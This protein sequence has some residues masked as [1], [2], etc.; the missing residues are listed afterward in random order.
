MG[1]I[2]VSIRKN[3]WRNLAITFQIILGTIVLSQAL[4]NYRYF[5]ATKYKAETLIESNVY[6]LSYT[7]KSHNEIGN[8]D[9]NGQDT[10]SPQEGVNVALKFIKGDNRVEKIGLESGGYVFKYADDEK[11]SKP[12]LKSKIQSI[13]VTAYNKELTEMY[14]FKVKKGISFSDYFK[15]NNDDKLIPILISEELAGDNPVGSIVKLPQKVDPRQKDYKIIGIL[16]SS[17][18][19]LSQI[20]DMAM[21][22]RPNDGYFCIIGSLIN[23]DYAHV[24]AKFKDD[25][26]RD[27]VKKDYDKRAGADKEIQFFGLNDMA[28]TLLLPA[29][30]KVQYI[31]YGTIILILTSFGV[32]GTVLASIVKRK[33][34]FGVRVAIGA[35]KSNIQRLVMGELMILFMFSVTIGLLISRLMSGM[36]KIPT[37]I[38]DFYVI[39]ISAGIVFVLMIISA[40]PSLLRITKMNPVDLVHGK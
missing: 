26:S 11:S 3:I 6:D 14:N 17:Y 28:E 2:L 4:S 29:S 36:S 19:L 40:I 32:I 13:D 22:G 33:P 24:Y 27:E 23:D 1:I 20:Y 8:H 10:I 31:F 18:P 38:W 35:T 12:I 30:E 25:V 39:G 7:N 37:Y 16:D 34:E 5:I 15:V 9:M 21:P